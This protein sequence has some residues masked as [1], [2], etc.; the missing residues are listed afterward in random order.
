MTKADL[1]SRQAA[2][3]RIKNICDEYR[4]SYEDGER[5]T[6]T[7]GSAYALG[8]AFDDLPPVTQ[9]K[10]YTNIPF[11]LHKEFGCPLDEC[12]KAYEKAIDY[13]RRQGKVSG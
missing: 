2:Q 4:L 11:L 8:H 1:I 13:L 7:G 5:K 12:V 3:A 9:Q 10:T 6:T